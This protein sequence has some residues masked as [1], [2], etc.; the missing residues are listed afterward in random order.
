MNKW[1]VLMLLVFVSCEDDEPKGNFNGDLN[2]DEIV[3]LGN[4]LGAGV[5]DGGWTYVTGLNSYANLVVRQILGEENVGDGTN[6]EP[7]VIP[8]PG[9]PGFPVPS[10]V[11]RYVQLGTYADGSPV[12]SFELGGGGLDVNAL[13]FPNRIHSG[14]FS[15]LAVPGGI[16]ADMVNETN[17]ATAW[18]GNNP[19]FGAVLRGLGTA[20]EQA[21]SKEPTF[22]ICWLG[23]NELLI[24]ALSGGIRGP[25]PFTD[26]GETEGYQTVFSKLVNDLTAVGSK[27]I[28]STAPDVSVIPALTFVGVPKSNGSL[29]YIVDLDNDGVFSDTLSFWGFDGT[30]AAR[31]LSSDERVPLSWMNRFANN[32]SYGLNSNTPLP[33][34][35]WLD[36]D[37]LS[38]TRNTLT[39][40]NNFLLGLAEN[41]DDVAIVDLNAILIEIANQGG[42]YEVPGTDISLSFD[43]PYGGIFSTD[44][45]H[46]SPSGAAFIANEFIKV[47]NQEFG[48][49]IAEL[50]IGD[51]YTEPPAPEQIQAKGFT[52]WPVADASALVQYLEL[53]TGELQ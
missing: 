52:H 46:P 12:L 35:G 17:G 15:N 37:E 43:L 3:V 47:I 38:A 11:S 2:V 27:V 36:A 30:G 45:I 44:G 50:N 6:N 39:Q 9:E 51:F 32:P 16:A 53:I 13:N 10:F 20:I 24:D 14:P 8:R 33:D 31:V 26:D 5:M 1:Y 40:M 25:Y 18:G 48:A 41:N 23:G 22:A 7:F 34:D 19:L 21:V 4:S 42:T 28:I 49:D 29:G